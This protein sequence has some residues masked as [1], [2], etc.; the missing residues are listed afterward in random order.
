MTHQ[1]SGHIEPV[2]VVDL[3]PPVGV[4]N[5]APT[6]GVVNLAPP[7]GVV[8]LAPPAVVNPGVKYVTTQKRDIPGRTTYN[9]D[10]R[11]KI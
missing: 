3:A 1:N 10:P 4:V 6:V 2:G 9:L 5:L 7:V 8:D 11:V